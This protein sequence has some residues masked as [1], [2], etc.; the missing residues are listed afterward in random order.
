MHLPII[1]GFIRKQIPK[2]LNPLK[3]Y[4]PLLPVKNKNK[5]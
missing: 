3:Y 2:N 1:T 4:L 5:T